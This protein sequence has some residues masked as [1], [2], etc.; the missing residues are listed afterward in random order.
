MRAAA[1]PL[2]QAW[3]HRACTQTGGW[4]TPLAHTYC[5]CVQHSPAPRS[6][7]HRSP[8]TLAVMYAQPELLHLCLNPT[9]LMASASKPALCAPACHVLFHARPVCAL[10]LWIFKDASAVQ[11]KCCVWLDGSSTCLVTRHEAVLVRGEQ[12]APITGAS[13][14]PQVLVVVACLLARTHARGGA[15]ISSTLHHG[16]LPPLA[17]AWRLGAYSSHA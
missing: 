3:L 9:A 15:K 8:H 4:L 6:S 5:L 13:Q 10:Q 16:H 17:Q 1:L 2:P 11:P 14:L 7:Q 12:S